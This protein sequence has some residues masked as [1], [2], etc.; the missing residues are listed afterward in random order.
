MINWDKKPTWAKCVARFEDGRV[1]WCQI[2]PWP[3]VIEKAGKTQFIE[4]QKPGE[5]TVTFKPQHWE[6]RKDPSYDGFS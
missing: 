4:T 1:Y 5:R 6:E 3:I 2:P